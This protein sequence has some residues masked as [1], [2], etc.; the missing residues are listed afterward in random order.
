MYSRGVKVVIN[1]GCSMHRTSPGFCILV[2]YVILCSLPVMVVKCVDLA[3]LLA[4]VL[5]R[6]KW[7]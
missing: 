6:C 2:I 7:F 1:T 4:Y 3:R 5:P